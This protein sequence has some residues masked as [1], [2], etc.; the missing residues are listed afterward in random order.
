VYSCIQLSWGG[1]LKKLFEKQETAIKRVLGAGV[2]ITPNTRKFSSISSS[3]AAA[4][5]RRV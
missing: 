1:P 2:E 5:K 4:A 3:S